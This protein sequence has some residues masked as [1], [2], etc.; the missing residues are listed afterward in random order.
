MWLPEQAYNQAFWGTP[1][2]KRWMVLNPR[3]CIM[4]GVLYPLRYL[5]ILI[6]G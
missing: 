6:Y 1:H 3:T 5:G 2:K 4:H